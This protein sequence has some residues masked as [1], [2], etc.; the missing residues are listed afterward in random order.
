M[1]NNISTETILLDVAILCQEYSPVK[2]SNMCNHTIELD[3][4]IITFKKIF[5]PYGENFGINSILGN[6]PE[7][8]CY[9]TFLPPFRTINLGKPFSLLEQIL[10]NIETDLNVTRNCFSTDSL[11]DFS[12]EISDIKSLVN[13]NSCNIMCSLKWANIISIIKNEYITRTP[14]NPLKEVLLIIS[15]VFKT[16]NSHILPN[17]IKFSYRIRN[18]KNLIS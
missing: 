14:T 7:Y 17:T 8:N 4:I 18:I 6:I 15:V 9:I 1:Q 10:A 12:K 3:E 2:A 13:I 5:Y 11:I 16:P